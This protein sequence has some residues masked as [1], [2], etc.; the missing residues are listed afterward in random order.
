[1]KFSKY[2]LWLLMLVSVAMLCF[3]GMAETESV[4]QT[5]GQFIDVSTGLDAYLYWT[6]A[7]VII[8]I[9]ALV[10][11]SVLNLK[12]DPKGALGAIIGIVVFAALLGVC[13]VISPASE[14]FV[15]VVN[16][17]TEVVTVGWLK[18]IDMWINSIVALISVVIL[19][20]VGFAAKRAIVK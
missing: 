3:F 7:I 4:Q 10:V 13:Y 2:I 18:V 17:E 12:N 15:R 11:L 1:M 19:L 8:A 6:E 9:V 16:G 5:T 14:D 20:V